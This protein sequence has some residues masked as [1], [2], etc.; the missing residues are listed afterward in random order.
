ME[1]AHDPTHHEPKHGGGQRNKEHRD[2]AGRAEIEP[3]DEIKHRHVLNEVS[4]VAEVRYD[5][6][7]ERGDSGEV[8]R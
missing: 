6:K 3:F 8:T 2:V 1:S 5:W 4:D 7:I